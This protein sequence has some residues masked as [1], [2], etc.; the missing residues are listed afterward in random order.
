MAEMTSFMHACKPK[1]ID[2]DRKEPKRKILDEKRN[3]YIS[4]SSLFHQ[5]ESPQGGAK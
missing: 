5:F 1:Q 3:P 2:K 4:E